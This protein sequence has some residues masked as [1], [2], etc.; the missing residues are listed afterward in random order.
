MQDTNVLNVQLDEGIDR[1]LDYLAPIEWKNLR[2]GIRVLVTLRG[3]KVKGT[4]LEIKNRSAFAKLQPALEILTEEGNLTDELFQLA[5]WISH[6]YA[7]PL[8]RV[9]RLFIPS[10]MRGKASPKKQ[11]RIRRNKP[12]NELTA[13]CKELQQKKPAQAK[14]LEVLLKRPKGILLTEL[15]EE[16]QGSISPVTTLAKQELITIDEMEI[17]RTPFDAFP[18]FPTK[19]KTLSEEQKRALSTLLTDIKENQFATHLLHGITGSGKTE[20]YLQ[21]MAETMSLNRSILMLVPEIALTTQTAERLKSRF[22]EK[23]AIL[24]HR[25]SFGERYDTWLAISRGE[26]PIVVGARSALF[27][28]L[29]NLGLIIVDEEHDNSYKQTDE[30][31]CYNGRDV[32]IMRAKMANAVCLL[33]SA[34]PSLETYTNAIN[35]KYKLNTL[36]S[37]PKNAT[38]PKITLVDLMREA[39][40][41]KRIPLLSAPL[42]SAI[43]KRAAIGEQSLLFLNRRGYNSLLLCSACNESIKCPHCELS[44]TFHKQ[45][46]L[47]TCHLCDF[48]INPPPRKCPKCSA[49]TLNYRGAG[50]EQVERTIKAIFPEIRTLRMDADTTRHKGSHDELFKQFRSGKADVLIGTQ[51]IAKGLHFPAVTLVGVLN[52]DGAMNIPDFRASENL[53]QLVTQV[54]GR[55]GRSLLEGEVIIQSRQP[56][57][58]LI[59][60]AAKDDYENFY[61]RE[62]KERE[63]F[64]YPPFTQIA[65]LIFSGPKDGVTMSFAKD[66]HDILIKLLPAAYEILPVVPCGYAKIRDRFRFQFLIKG[67]KQGFTISNALISLQTK[68]KPPKET[69]YTIDIDPQST[70]F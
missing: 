28:P 29:P 12:L 1:A 62:I 24:H 33:G 50:T 20:V 13:L 19:P 36:K 38:R 16:T 22:Q 5:E 42:L 64:K 8:R 52:S 34:T 43:E 67:P 57:H 9:L 68:L 69:K 21:A 48:T 63:M 44:L 32:A 65:R 55:S 35:G 49:E 46:N 37:R 47:L 4:V 25:L 15:L 27:C 10:A 58:P 59:Q 61:K 70:H 60:L 51:M 45:K 66:A 40:K 56:S 3:R 17:D 53:F 30:M 11:K 23:I 14:V 54:A 39:E 18:Y 2:P 7:T 31:P 26:I 41:E 6:Y